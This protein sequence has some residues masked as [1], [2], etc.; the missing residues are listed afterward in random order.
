[1]SKVIKGV[2]IKPNHRAIPYDFEYDSFQDFHTLLDCECFDIA[3]RRFGDH[4]YDI[5][6]DDEGLLV[7]KK[8]AIITFDNDD[9]V[10]ETLVGICF[11]CKH[12]DKGDTISLEDDE[13]KEVLNSNIF[14]V[15]YCEL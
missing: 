10:C 2:L 9:Q 12:D 3:T 13:V 4:Y 7:G 11:I 8:P 6:L 5:Y 1:M 14:G 15:P